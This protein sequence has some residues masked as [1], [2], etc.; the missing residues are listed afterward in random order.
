M[1]DCVRVATCSSLVSAV[2]QDRGCTRAGIC[3]DTRACARLRK[4]TGHIGDVACASILRCDVVRVVSVASR[5]LSMYRHIYRV[6]LFLL[7]MLVK[8]DAPYFLRS[9]CREGV[10]CESN[11]ESPFEAEYSS[12]M[13]KYT[14]NK[15][16]SLGTTA[17]A[18]PTAQQPK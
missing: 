14:N 5:S 10:A 18:H 12:Y 6:F 17:V 15:Q 4:C 3:A 11:F 13:T 9:M 8:C 16:Q 7:P 1:H 2:Y